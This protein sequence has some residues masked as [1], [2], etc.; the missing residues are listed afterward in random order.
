MLQTSASK[1]L[2]DPA[3]LVFAQRIALSGSR[4]GGVEMQECP[5]LAQSIQELCQQVCQSVAAE[6]FR[7]VFV[8]HL[9]QEL[10]HNEHPLIVNHWLS[11]LHSTALQ[12]ANKVYGVHCNYQDTTFSLKDTQSNCCVAI[13]Q[14]RDFF[15]G[16]R[17]NQNRTATLLVSLKSYAFNKILY[18]TYPMIR[19]EVGDKDLGRTNLGLFNRYSSK[20]IAE[21]L[22]WSRFSQTQIEQIYLPLQ[23]CAR[24]Y[25]RHNAIRVNQL[26]TD[27]FQK[28]GEL[29][30]K[31]T[32]DLPPPIVDSLETIGTSLR[33]FMDPPTISTDPLN[34]DETCSIGA[35]LHSLVAQPEEEMERQGI[36]T[37]ID[38]WLSSAVPSNQQLQILWLKYHCNLSQVSIAAIMS[39]DQSQVCRRLRQVHVAISKALLAEFNPDGNNSPMGILNPVIEVL[40]DR[41][42]DFSINQNNPAVRKDLD[43]LVAQQNSLPNIRSGVDLPRSVREILSILY[44]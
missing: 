41:I 44:S 37:A 8:Q 30:Q 5:R 7:G 4:R 27:D 2:I 22:Q 25:L 32:G 9:L 10:R 3:L 36:F 6:E 21:A 35:T 42:N 29:Y 26:T 12:V 33:R 11:F 43:L 38:Q 16:F 40:K 19:K 23:G 14:T 1:Q 13:G 15:A 34:A 20:R 17:I 24:E 18:S 31:I 39:S 28:I